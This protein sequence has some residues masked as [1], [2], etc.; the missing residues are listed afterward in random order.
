MTDGNRFVC[1]FTDDQIIN[2]LT[3]QLRN[4]WFLTEKDLDD[5]HALWPFAKSRLAVCLSRIKNKYY[6]VQIDGG[7]YP[8]F[9][10]LHS[11]QYAM[12]LYFLSNAMFQAQV[13][14]SLCDRI[15]NLNKTLSSAE[16]YYEVA[17]PEIFFFDHPLGSVMGRAK[18]S[19]FFSFS[20]GCTVGNNHANYPVFNERVAMLSNSKVI[21]KCAIGRNTII[22]ANTYVKDSDIPENSIVFGAS[23]NLKIIQKESY[24]N[25]YMNSLYW[26]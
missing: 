17:L 20:Q 21:G 26:F 16:L 15:Y 13:N 14:L 4:L 10:P 9:S 6:S 22:S 3:N 5:I 23:P 24:V 2:I 7:G 1:E 11:C 8:K 25:K 12:L 19:N 18:Y